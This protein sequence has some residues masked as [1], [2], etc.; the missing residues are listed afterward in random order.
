[1]NVACYAA[2]IVCIAVAG[3]SF[4]KH[5]V[6][7]MAIAIEFIGVYNSYDDD[8]TRFEFCSDE[9]KV[10]HAFRFVQDKVE[11]YQILL[12]AIAVAATVVSTACAVFL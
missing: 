11:Q 6:R 4:H 2:G 3:A 10:L 5:V 7:A 12:A 8:S 9:G 1:M